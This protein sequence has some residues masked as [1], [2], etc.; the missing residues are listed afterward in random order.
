MFNVHGDR[1]QWWCKECFRTYFRR[2]GDKHRAQ[3]SV[4]KEQRRIRARAVVAKHLAA[5]ACADC[6]EADPI[7]FEFD[8]IGSK[9]MDVSRMVN[10]GA[11]PRD[12][13]RE[14]S[15]CEVVCAN[16]HRRRTGIRCGSWRLS[17]EALE[18]RSSLSPE[19]RRNLRFMRDV[20]ER[21]HCVDCGLDDILVLEFDHVRGVKERNVSKLVREGR[22][23][24]RLQAEIAK[25]DVRCASCHRRRTVER[26]VANA[27]PKLR[28]PP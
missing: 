23:L 7:V 20:L 13:Q 12:L 9:R 25:C 15:V 2:R 1:R 21:S 16:C 6:G 11:N 8:H 10:L 19:V 24:R 4:A 17:P 26:R 18:R 28:L 3:S 22:S 5:S 27:G 14:I